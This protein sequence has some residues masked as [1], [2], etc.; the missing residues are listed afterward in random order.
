IVMPQTPPSPDFNTTYQDHVFAEDSYF[1][2]TQLDI[3]QHEK[4]KTM[5]AIFAIGAILLGSDLLALLMAGSL[6]ATT[7][8]YTL[9]A[10]VLYVLLGLFAQR[11]PLVAAI[12][13]S[14]VFIAIIAITIYAFGARSIV[15]GLLLKAVVIFFII[16]GFNHAREAERAKRNL[17]IIS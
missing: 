9:V 10:P 6:T 15:S 16:S 7:F 3:W 8:A 2:E 12:I 14:L 17:K 11:Q 13:A 5:Q 4:K 1:K